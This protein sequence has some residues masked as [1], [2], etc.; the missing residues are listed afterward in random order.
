MTNVVWI[1]MWFVVVPEQ[2]V[3]YYSLGEYANETLCKAGMKGATVMVNDK[4]ETIECIGVKVN[5]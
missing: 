5:D 2:G 4:N 1:L 3:R